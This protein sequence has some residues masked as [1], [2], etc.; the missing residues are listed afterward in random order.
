VE[1]TQLISDI[2]IMNAFMREIEE[3]VKGI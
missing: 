1:R 2:K 3:A